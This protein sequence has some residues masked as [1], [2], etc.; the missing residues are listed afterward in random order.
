MKM[1]L[2]LALVSL[3]GLA[4]FGQTSPPAPN[5]EK[6]ALLPDTARFELILT[7]STSIRL[8]RYTGRSF[9]YTTEGGLFSQGGRKWRI[10]VVRG[11]LP[12]AAG[13]LTPV[14][15]I[16]DHGYNIFLINN[17]TGQTWILNGQTWEPVTD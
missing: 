4:A 13:T 1:F 5:N 6:R 17:Q 2:A 8:D 11:G 12:A 9:Y 15:Q 10:F 14:Y 16:Y 7:G 3:A